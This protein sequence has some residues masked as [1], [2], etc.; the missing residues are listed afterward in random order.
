MDVLER[1]RIAAALVALRPDWASN[2]VDRLKS[3]RVWLTANLMDWSYRDALVGLV[4][5]ASD[6]ASVG[7]ARLLTDGPWRTALRHLTGTTL[8]EQPLRDV[9]PECATCGIQRAYHAGVR[10]TIE[11]GPHEFVPAAPRPVASPQAIA[12]ARRA[13][14]STKG[15]R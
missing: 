11:A 6:T 2:G 4:L 9:G 14:F 15:N 7:P 10:T 8:T 13:A 12:N 5:V 3:L 1:D